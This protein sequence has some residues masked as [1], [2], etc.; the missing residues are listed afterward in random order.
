MTFIDPKF[1]PLQ[2]KVYTQVTSSVIPGR[3]CNGG[4]AAQ[5][6]ILGRTSCFYLNLS[7]QS[8]EQVDRSTICIISIGVRLVLIEKASV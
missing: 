8:R 6:L 3:D 7:T 2:R 5:L 4:S 1:P